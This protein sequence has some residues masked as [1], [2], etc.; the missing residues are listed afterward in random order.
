M[1]NM[2]EVAEEIEMAGTVEDMIKFP[3]IEQFSTV[4][5][6]IHHKTRYLGKNEDGTGIYDAALPLPT[7]RYRG[8][9]K[10]HGTHADIV[11]NVKTD[12]VHY[13][14]R[15][16]CITVENDNHGFAAFIQQRQCSKL[17]DE[18]RKINTNSYDGIMISGEF[19]GG[20]IQSGVALSQLPKMF[21][22]YSI[23][24]TGEKSYYA[25]IMDYKN[26]HDNE[27]G[28]YN[29]CQFP[30]Y[31]V[32]INFEQPKL[33]QPEL[34]RLTLEVEKKCPVG[35]FFGIHGVGEGVVWNCIDGDYNGYD[36]FSFKVKGDQHSATKVKKMAN[37]NIEKVNS[38]TEFV[39]ATVTASRLHQGVEYL[40]E[41]GIV[42]TEFKIASD[43][44]PLP[45]G[46]FIKWVINDIMKEDHAMLAKSKLKPADVSKEIASKAKSW[47]LNFIQKN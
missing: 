13:Q 4:I 34:I 37:I 44:T 5:K 3:S 39:D 2:T 6:N 22:I 9:V 18:I 31:E 30:I 27:S 15:N 26:I 28:I 24:F 38:I 40:K 17:F 19:C 12:V 43:S 29:I 8:T 46:S 25:D 20:N 11:L 35:A 21:V 47:Y 33:I 42:Q 10:L 45:L 41:L 23:K 16:K 14:S 7:L 36:K 1:S 32:D